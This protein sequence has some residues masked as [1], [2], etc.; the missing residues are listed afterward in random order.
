MSIFIFIGT[1]PPP[2]KSVRITKYSDFKRGFENMFVHAALYRF[3]PTYPLRIQ[4]NNFREA[5]ND[6]PDPDF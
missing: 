6:K 3:D 2:V 1:V 5:V 4:S